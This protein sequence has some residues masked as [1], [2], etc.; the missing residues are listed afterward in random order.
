VVHAIHFFNLIAVADSPKM[1][2]AVI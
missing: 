1:L 2:T